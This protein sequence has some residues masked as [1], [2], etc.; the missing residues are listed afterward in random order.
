MLRHDLGLS[1]CI[2]PTTCDGASAP[3]CSSSCR[4]TSA[5]AVAAVSGHACLERREL[6]TYVSE[7]CL[8][9]REA[10]LSDAVR[11]TDQQL[12]YLLV[13]F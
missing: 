1:A 7:L 12:Q 9:T 8:N 13:G 2:L 4:I 5:Q 10:H 3:L 11:R 6:L